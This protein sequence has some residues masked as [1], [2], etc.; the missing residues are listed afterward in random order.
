MRHRRRAFVY[1][2]IGRLCRL[3]DTNW[4][5]DHSGLTN[6]P[7]RAP[8]SL[9]MRVVRGVGGL[10]VLGGRFPQGSRRREGE[11]PPTSD[12]PPACTCVACFKNLERDLRSSERALGDVEARS[13]RGGGQPPVLRTGRGSRR[14]PG[15]RKAILI[16]VALLATVAIV[17]AAV[18]GNDQNVRSR[19]DEFIG[20]PGPSAATATE[21]PLDIEGRV[22]A[23]VATAR[24]GTQPHTGRSD[25]D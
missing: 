11:H 3:R 9:A 10:S 22:Q 20:R 16:A 7:Q 4:P 21:T 12:H 5:D 15:K 14:S 8:A 24:N 19:V 23:A 1:S 6:T 25:Y 17:A 2:T 18:Y 13:S